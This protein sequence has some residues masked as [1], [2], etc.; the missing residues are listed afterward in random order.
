MEIVNTAREARRE[1]F[2][3]LHLNPK[4]FKGKMLTPRAKRAEKSLA[5][6]T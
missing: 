5:F 1:N 3:I 6:Y 2:S 4:Y